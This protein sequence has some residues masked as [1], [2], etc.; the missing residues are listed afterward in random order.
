[1]NAPAHL[2]GKPLQLTVNEINFVASL[3]ARGTPRGDVVRELTHQYP[4]RFPAETVDSDQLS[5]HL[6]KYDPRSNG[7]SHKYHHIIALHENAIRKAMGDDYEH[8]WAEI[9]EDVFGRVK[10]LRVSIGD[11][12][13]H[14]EMLQREAMDLLRRKNAEKE[15]RQYEMYHAQYIDLDK[16]MQKWHEVRGKEEERLFR[17]FFALQE[18]EGKMLNQTASV[19]EAVDHQ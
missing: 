14:I 13:G 4:D 7:F 5:N 10:Q 18:L 15:I 3:F 2:N 12:D 8:L 19:M 6:R 16:Q 9:R 1:M 17:M 11:I